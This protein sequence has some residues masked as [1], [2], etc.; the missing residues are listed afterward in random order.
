MSEDIEPIIDPN[1]GIKIW[2][3]PS[4]EDQCIL[5]AGVLHD[6]LANAG[7]LVRELELQRSASGKKQL[8]LQAIEYYSEQVFFLLKGILEEIHKN[9]I[10]AWRGVSCGLHAR[11]Q[12]EKFRPSAYQDWLDRLEASASDV[13]TN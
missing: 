11:H 13:P 7:A 10:A 2:A 6:V 5:L 12:P 1:T 8:Q 3:N 4:P 9:R